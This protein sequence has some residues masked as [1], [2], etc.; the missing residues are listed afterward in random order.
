MSNA[1]HPG[2]ART[3]LIANGPGA[4]SVLARINSVLVRPFL[5]QS[6]AEGALPVLVPAT[7]T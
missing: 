7:Y 1:A 4:D 3:E 5:S 2:Y 6:A